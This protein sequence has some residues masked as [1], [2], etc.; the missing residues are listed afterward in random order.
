MTSP[1][2]LT[3]TGG[4][5]GKTCIGFILVRRDN[6]EAF[7]RDEKSLGKFPSVQEAADAISAAQVKR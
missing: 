4:A 3:V 1:K 5:D 2:M 6:F 7:D